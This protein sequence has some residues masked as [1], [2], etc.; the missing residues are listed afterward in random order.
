MAVDFQTQTPT[1]TSSVM[2]SDKKKTMVPPQDIMWAQACNIAA[3][4]EF[5]KTSLVQ[6]RLFPIYGFLVQ[7]EPRKFL[8]ARPGMT[9]LITVTNQ[10]SNPPETK[11]L[12]IP[13]SDLADVCENLVEVLQ[14]IKNK[15]VF[16]KFAVTP[17]LNRLTFIADGFRARYGVHLRH[18]WNDCIITPVG[19]RLESEGLAKFIHNWGYALAS[20]FHSHSS[21]TLMSLLEGVI[22]QGRREG[23]QPSLINIKSFINLALESDTI[24]DTAK[25]STQ[26]NHRMML[27]KM[28]E[29]DAVAALIQPETTQFLQAAL[30]VRLVQDKYISLDRESRDEMSY[31]QV[32]NDLEANSQ[33]KVSVLNEEADSNAKPKKSRSYPTSPPA[34]RKRTSEMLLIKKED[35]DHV[36]SCS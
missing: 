17:R 24:H 31:Q 4:A 20:S 23:R 29:S 35:E 28:V 36:D 5:G 15:C 30:Y 19:V 14:H 13:H 16:S 1:T 34:K 7:L 33:K 6:Q 26:L 9:V 27:G 11:E 12:R 32:I 18:V 10:H 22:E 3:E 21:D 2:D 8:S 25:L